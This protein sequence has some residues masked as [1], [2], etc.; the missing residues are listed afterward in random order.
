MLNFQWIIFNDVSLRAPEGFLN[1]NYPNTG[2]CGPGY[3]LIE[4]L[5]PDSILG[6]NIT[7]ICAI[8]DY[9][10][11]ITNTEE[12]KIEADI[13]LFANGFRLIKNKSRNKFIGFLRASI[14]G[15]Y[16]YNCAYLSSFFHEIGDQNEDTI[17][18]NTD[19]DSN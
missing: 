16:F 17:Q 5:V 8:H 1:S 10:Y 12:E 11:F 7:I 14:L 3:G 19:S 18:H 9:C 6:L 4:K 15:I 2:K 13:E